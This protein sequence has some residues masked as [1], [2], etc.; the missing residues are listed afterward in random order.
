M[1]LREWS[2]RLRLP[3]ALDDASGQ[4]IGAA[5]A[6]L[7]REA[8]SGRHGAPVRLDDGRTLWVMRPG[9][10]RGFGAARA[11]AGDAERAPG[12]PGEGGRPRPPGSGWPA[13]LLAPQWPPGVGLLA[14]LALLF[15][16][17]AAGAYPVVRSLTRRLESLQAGVERFGAGSLGQRVDESGRDEVAAVAR[18]FNLAAERV[19]TLLRSHQSLLANA[20][21]ELRSP[22][23][24]LKMAVAMLPQAD[25]AHRDA[26]ASRGRGQHRRA[27]CAGRRGA[28][29]QPARRRCLV[30]QAA[31][32]SSCSAWPPKRRRAST[33]R[34]SGAPCTVSGDERLLRRALRNLLENARRYGAGEIEVFVEREGSSARLRVCDRGPGV[35]EG[36]RERIFEAFFRL[37]GHAEREGGVGLGLSL[38]KQ[39]A[40]RHGGSVRC[41]ARDGGGSC[42]VITLPA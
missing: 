2:L 32:A 18:S 3:M 7:R 12:P 26:L 36:Y 21:H 23:A 29:G 10:A 6:Y 42:F 38:V 37:P 5:D 11:A 22:L 19:E 33:R 17:V 15:V 35:P 25:G 28:A 39:I 27:R 24:R 9:A 34:S 8:D 40:E 20:S 16:A 31:R 14:L 41:E 30:A 13:M 1:A 4:R